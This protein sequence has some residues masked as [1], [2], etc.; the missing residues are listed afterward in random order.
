LRRELEASGLRNATVKTGYLESLIRK[1]CQVQRC[2]P[3][4][5][6][7]QR[8]LLLHEIVRLVKRRQYVQRAHIS[9][10]EFG[11]I[12]LVVLV[13]VTIS[14]GFGFLLPV[15]ASRPVS[16]TTSIPV[17]VQPVIPLQPSHV[18]IQ[19]QPENL[20]PAES[21][22]YYIV[23]SGDD[24]GSVS[25][26]LGVSP[27]I[28]QT[29]NHLPTD[30]SLLS[31]QILVARADPATP[32]LHLSAEGA[33][34]SPALLT[35]RS[36]P[37]SI[38]QRIQEH[39]QFYQS[40]WA[41][42]QVVF[43]GPAGYSGPPRTFRVQIWSVP[44]RNLMIA[45]PA[46]GV[47][48]GALL[49]TTIPG[50][51]DS[52]K[53]TFL[54]LR[55]GANS[56]WFYSDDEL[57]KN[58]P[59]IQRL[60]YPVDALK[61]VQNMLGYEPRKTIFSPVR[62]EKL[63]GRITLV[64]DIAPQED[65]KR[66]R[67]WVDV[68]NGLILRWQHFTGLHESIVDWEVTFTRVLFDTAIHPNLIK[69]YY[70]LPDYF[71]ED[72]QGFP[73]KR[74]ADKTSSLTSPAF[75]HPEITFPTAPRDFD[76]GNQWL[77]FQ[78]PNTYHYLAP[79]A[80]VEIFSNQYYLGSMKFGNPW[81]LVCSRAPNGYLM[82]YVSVPD[83]QMEDTF[84]NWFD[85]RETGLPVHSILGGIAIK[86]LVF[87]PDSHFLAAYGSHENAG[88]IYLVDMQTQSIRQ[89]ENVFDARS[90]A[91][92]PDSNYLA[93]IARSEAASST[94]ILLVIDV[95]DGQAIYRSL[96]NPQDARS[97]SGSPL[98]DWDIPFP[99]QPQGLEGCA[100]PPVRNE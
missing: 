80:D 8:G 82:A 66:G 71:A 73:E 97:W 10:Q 3:S 62:L 87:S 36:S 53:Q 20:Y 67:L 13:I 38:L 46:A 47:P 57:L 48:A 81:T 89:F 32:G 85:L 12:S 59:S 74:K 65:G 79:F 76:P 72:Q 34:K 83:A 54:A 41:E 1:T 64:T 26:R 95:V 68:E 28:L 69:P 2:D 96:W 49:S 17:V 75:T 16:Q 29:L 58:T 30:G 77:V 15:P 86:E 39:D 88:G 22:I 78:Y 4:L 70:F 27:E 18:E 37:S 19:T 100:R 14:W 40:M 55:S 45:G 23:Q 35:P 50:D 6:P 51:V 52:P 33:P 93:M 84:L 44:G 5:T 91:W 42:G 25:R 99:A 94:E 98:R 90:L 24:Q 63:S 92:S 11:T 56:Q 31:G 9:A 61:I 7:N 43:Y 60:A 21:E